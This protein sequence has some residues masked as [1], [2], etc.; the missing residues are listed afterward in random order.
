MDYKSV[1]LS[2]SSTALQVMN[3]HRDHPAKAGK[4]TREG[5]AKKRS[6]S[7]QHP[8]SASKKADRG[9]KREQE[10]EVTHPA[11]KR[12][13]QQREQSPEAE[14]GSRG[15]KKV[16][17]ASGKT[18][19]WQPLSD[20]ST[21]HLR[22]MMDSVILSILSKP[23]KEKDDIQKHLNLLKERLLRRYKAL[24]VPLGKLS[25]LKNVLS[26]KVAEKQNLSSNEEA[27]ALLQVFQKNGTGVLN[28]PELPKHSLQAPTL[29]EEIL[30]IQNQ[31]GIL[32]DLITIQHSDEMKNMLTLLEQA[33]EKV[34]SL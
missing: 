20:S 6:K 9:R 2:S 7:Q 11:K 17:L 28:L 23:I 34:D 21:E 22:V 24:K 15:T 4:S 8:G 10:K 14:T 16:K 12:E 31:K 29:Q 13:K 33:Y 26:L 19:A 32:K 5:I 1:S 30:K 25:N 18:A 27:M 3:H